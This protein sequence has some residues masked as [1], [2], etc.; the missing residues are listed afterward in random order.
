MSAK[1]A[2]QLGHSQAGSWRISLDFGSI[3]RLRVNG[4]IAPR[5][6]TSATQSPSS[7]SELLPNE[8][9]LGR[10]FPR[11]PRAIDQHRQEAP[12][13]PQRAALPPT[14]SPETYSLTLP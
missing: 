11:P 13:D 3:R 5:L 2:R 6:E 1:D 10:R 8:S 7:A 14:H 4:G 9:R 12:R